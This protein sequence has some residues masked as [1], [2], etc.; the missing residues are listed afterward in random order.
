MLEAGC[1]AQ[2]AEARLFA[3][4]EASAVDARED[5]VEL[6]AVLEALLRLAEQLLSQRGRLHHEHLLRL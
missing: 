1:A 6:P 4:R 2:R 3:V 5:L